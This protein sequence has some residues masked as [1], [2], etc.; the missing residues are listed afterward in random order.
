MPTTAVP[1]APM[2]VHTA[3]A[4]PS[5]TPC[6]A[7][8]SSQKLKSANRTK[9][10]VGQSRLKPSESLRNVVNPISNRPARKRYSQATFVS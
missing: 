4:V 8:L 5:G 2:P 10:T 3:Y 9:N 6:S 1:K 7:L